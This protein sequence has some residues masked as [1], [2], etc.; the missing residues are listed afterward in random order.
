MRI[1]PCLPWDERGV[2]D[3][4]NA[5]KK[6]FMVAECRSCHLSCVVSAGFESKPENKGDTTMQ[7]ILDANA[8][9]TLLAA[10]PDV[11]KANVGSHPVARTGATSRRRVWT[12]RVLS[13]VPV[14]FL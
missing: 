7:A 5:S 4:D 12:G 14:L 1:D 2:A 6:I 11:S 8:D 10:T 9:S 3:T 13:G